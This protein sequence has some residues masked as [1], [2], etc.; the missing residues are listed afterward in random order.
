M[1]LTVGQRIKVG[2]EKGYYWVTGVRLDGSVDVWGGDKDKNGSRK[3]RT[4]P[5]RFV[6]EDTRKLE[7]KH[8]PE[9]AL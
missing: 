2:R 6:Q 8:Y 7:R 3:A 9:F 1:S 5:S 4:I